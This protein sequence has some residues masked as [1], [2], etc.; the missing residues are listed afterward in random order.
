[1]P[2]RA[3]V[4]PAHLQARFRAENLSHTVADHLEDSSHRKN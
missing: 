4:S 3:P 1:L 2:G